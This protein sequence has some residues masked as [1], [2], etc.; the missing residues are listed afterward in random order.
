MSSPHRIWVGAIGLALLGFVGFS[1]LEGWS[2]FAV[3]SGTG[4][5]NVAEHDQVTIDSSS[6][7][8]DHNVAS[9]IDESA[10]VRDEVTTPT[11][12]RVMR[13]GEA[14][15]GARV[16]VLP[17][18]EALVTADGL[19]P[20]LDLPRL[21]AQVRE[22]FT[23][24]AGTYDVEDAGERT[25]VLVTLEG[26]SPFTGVVD[27]G[28]EFVA[29]LSDEK[30]WEVRIVDR[31]GAPIRGAEVVVTSDHAWSSSAGVRV[32]AISLLMDAMID[33]VS[34]SDANGVARFGMLQD[35]YYTVTARAPGYA[36]RFRY[37]AVL[38]FDPPTFHELTL[39]PAAALTG[40]VR[41][42]ES[43]APIP[44]ARVVTT[45]YGL[46]M[47]RGMFDQVFTD[48]SGAFGPVAVGGGEDEIGVI[49]SKEGY[50]SKSAVLGVIA[51][52]E[53]G[54]LDI[55][56]ERPKLFRGRIVSPVGVGLSNIIVVAQDVASRMRYDFARTRE[57]GTFEFAGAD[58]GD[59]LLL[60]AWERGVAAME[61][62]VPWPWPDPFEFTMETTAPVTGRIIADSYPLRDPEIRLVAG[63]KSLERT[64]ERYGRVAPETGAYEIPDVPRGR[65]RLEA[66]AADHAVATRREIEIGRVD[67]RDPVDIEV[68][69]GIAVRGTIRRADDGAPLAGATVT[70]ADR[71]EQTRVYVG[72]IRPPVPTDAEG[73]FELAPAPV[74]ERVAIQIAAEGF[75]TVIDEFVVSPGNAHIVRDV[76][77]PRE[78]MLKLRIKKPDG[79]F[80]RYFTMRVEHVESGMQRLELVADG[81]GIQ[82]GLPPG[83]YNLAACLH[84]TAGG[85]RDTSIFRDGVPLAAGESKEI[86]LEL[87]GTSVVR[88]ALRIPGGADRGGFFAVDAEP[89]DD[90]TRDVTMAMVQ[91]HDLTYRFVALPAG[92]YRLNAE[93]K[94]RVPPLLC[95]RVLDV[96]DG[97]EYVVD[98]EFGTQELTG[99]IVD[100]ASRPIAGARIGIDVVDVVGDSVTKQT[101]KSLE[102]GEYRVAGLREGTWPFT[103]RAEGF[104]RQEGTVAIRS[105]E[106]PSTKDFALELE[107]LVAITVRDR[108]GGSIGDAKVEA[109]VGG[110][111]ERDAIV[112]RES[113]TDGAKLLRE[114]GT[115]RHLL[116]VRRDGFFPHESWVACVG[117]QALDVAVTL[118]RPVRLELKLKQA[119]GAAM[120]EFDVE[121]TDVETGVL[122]T[123][124]Q[125]RGWLDASIP[126]RTD[127]EGSLVIE[128]IPEGRYRVRAG[129][130]DAEV[131]AEV[132]D[133][134]AEPSRIVLMAAY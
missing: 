98:F 65:Y 24:A 57:D 97:Q 11:R 27:A 127:R 17:R 5:P 74:S 87:G 31:D 79:G 32:D 83:T 72:G 56:L 12:V 15:A 80:S 36:S 73:R 14:V 118:R 130:I 19:L 96:A 20:T 133:R 99:V 8:E 114:L 16:L 129:G 18:D 29:E 64:F 103:I 53:S 54:S 13:G 9:A 108:A 51:V 62:G 126:L 91:R 125:V 30:R 37:N 94:N 69:R 40:R 120:A 106:A 82:R 116:A 117:G 66:W 112:A 38:T 10:A 47:L 6:V 4:E 95:E 26:C 113:R 121:L 46:A 75:A 41:D 77:L 22:G 131:D 44:N 89:L 42:A 85:V 115:G 45:G 67:E 1:I 39:V 28:K 119:N 107:A 84:D 2:E 81:V 55:E 124:W 70:Y 58:P 59:P 93:L 60:M 50:A 128:G 132:A 76:A 105:D 3:P 92:R 110:N 34:V 101:G 86:V 122:A 7:T 104:A 23:D 52:G 90:R 88:G 33:R 134:G 68:G 71:G 21:R 109:H 25:C 61:I 100:V 49:V 123:E 78:A 63:T 111:R 102:N 35:V 48:E 43:G